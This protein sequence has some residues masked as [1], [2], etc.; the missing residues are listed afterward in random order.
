MTINTVELSIHQNTKNTRWPPP[1]PHKTHT[2]MFFINFISRLWS[3]TLIHH[4]KTKKRHRG[5]SDSCINSK[6]IIQLLMIVQLMNWYGLV[7]KIEWC[8]FSLQL[9][10]SHWAVK[11]LKA[12]ACRNKND[13]GSIWFIYVL[14]KFPLCCRK[15]SITH[16]HWHYNVF[17]YASDNCP[18]TICLWKNW[19]HRASEK[20]WSC[21]RLIYICSVKIMVASMCVYGVV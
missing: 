14:S 18:E 19:R 3:Q 8:F 15:T 17:N 21:D 2:S 16:Q 11:E 13:H 1:L 7:H 10:W 9:S 12:P 5:V 4:S 20:M 6:Q